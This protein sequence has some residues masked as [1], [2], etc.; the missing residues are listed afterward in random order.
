MTRLLHISADFPDAYSTRKTKAVHN[1]LGG[2]PE[3]EHRVYSLN[4]ENGVGGIHALAEDNG[5]TTLVYRAPSYGILLE[6]FLAPVSRW[7]VQDVQTRREPIDAIHAHKLTI[8]G[9][10]AQRVAHELGCP[11]VCTIRGNTDQRYIRM[12][13]GMRRHWRQVAGQASW[14]FPV[15]PW[16]DRYATRKLSLSGNRRSL[17]P[18]ATSIDSM[19]P[20]RPTETRLVTAFHLAGWR[21]KGMPRLLRALARL[22]D[23]GQ[24]VTLDIIGGGP[25]RETAELGREIRR[26]SLDG[27]VHLRGAIPHEQMA[28]TLNGYTGFV[29]PTLRETFGMVYLESLFA[30]T[31]ILYSQDRGI[32]GFFDNEDVGIRCDPTSVD[33]IAAGI[34]SLLANTDRLKNN[35]ARLQGTGGFNRFRLDAIC[36]D[37]AARMAAVV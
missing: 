7:I 13:P 31:P 9:L 19:I 3:F 5:V 1:L 21:L 22:R 30:G 35:I 10:V 12:K 15:T 27:Q 23:G 11:Y 37:Y 26:Y 33:S 16:I 25:E 32:D 36:R 4:R 34:E 29:L 17:L 8:E 2:V 20:P 28:E 14:L 24:P 6:Q 18:T